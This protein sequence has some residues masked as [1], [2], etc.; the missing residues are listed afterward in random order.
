MKIKEIE[1]IQTTP[2]EAAGNRNW[3]P[4]FVAVHTDEGI[5]GYGEIGLAYGKSHDAGVGQTIDYAKLIIGM[6]PMNIE[7]IWHKL[8]RSTFWGMSGG[9]VVF[10]AISAIDIALWDIKGKALGVPVWQLLGGKSRDS[11]RCYASQIQLG[12]GKK[13]YRH[14]QPEEYADA[15]CEAMDAGFDAVKVDPIGIDDKGGWMNWNTR[16]MLSND[17]L[18]LIEK[19]VAAIRE[20]GGNSLDI[21]IEAHS[22]TDTNTAIQVGQRLEPYRCFYFEEPTQPLNPDLFETVKSKV[23]I[24][25]AAGERIHS[26]WGFRPFLEKRL[27]SVIQPDTCNTGGITEVK[28]ICEMAEVYDTAV[29]LHVCGGPISNAVAMQIETVIPNFLIHETHEYS[30]VPANIELCKYDYQP[31]NGHLPIPE[32]PGIGQELS[33]NAYKNAEIV[34]VK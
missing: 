27:L 31:V 6:D 3:R 2:L 17:Q 14:V 10:S 12:W 16:N 29:Q 21:I 22:L 24:P 20:A 7:A 18:D 28:K 19:R 8:Q 11:I 5:T 26:R 15:T 13:G 25:L 32:R 1:I 34:T 30:I 4:A 33:E 23:N 9:P